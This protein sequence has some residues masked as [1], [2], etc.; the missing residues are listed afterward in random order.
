MPNSALSSNREFA[1]AGPR[2]SASTL[3]GVVG[4]VPAVDRG[5]SG[6]VRHDH[7]IAEQL[8]EHLQVR[9]LAAAGAGARELE[10][11]THLLGALHR[12]GADVG[13]G[14]IGDVQE[15]VERA[16]LHVE[17]LE[18]RLHVDGTVLHLFLAVG[19]THVDADPATGAVV[20]RHLDRHPHP[21]LLARLPFLVLEALGCALQRR[22]LEHLHPDGRVRADERAL[23]A[24]DA[25]RRIPDRDLVRDAP[26]LPAGRVG[27]E[28]PVDRERRHRQEVALPGDHLRGHPLH[29]LG[30]GRR[31]PAEGRAGRPVASA[32]TAT[33]CNPATAASTAAKFRVRTV[34]PRLP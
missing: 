1:H 20:G 6:R 19:R 26:L 11:R 29:E 7:P 23:G 14:R 12:V 15:E 8:R 32:G 33:S 16:A 17:V 22:R 3:H 9:G 31:A 24:V 34:S 4:H 30:G 2:P 27:R 21:G 28:R 13:A 10:Q 25:D 5:A 18:L